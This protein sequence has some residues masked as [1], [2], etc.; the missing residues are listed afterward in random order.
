MVSWPQEGPV[1]TSISSC[2]TLDWRR[3][4]P[5]NLYQWDL[6][7]GELH[8]KESCNLSLSVLMWIL[9]KSQGLGVSTNWKLWTEK[10]TR[11][12][13]LGKDSGAQN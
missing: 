7:M 11:S 9:E 10:P 2:G 1:C 8:I 6:W 3:I 4:E 12:E 5:A 13:V